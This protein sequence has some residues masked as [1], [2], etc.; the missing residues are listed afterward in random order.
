MGDD[1]KVAKGQYNPGVPSG[2]R[3]E[4]L[5]PT[6]RYQEAYAGIPAQMNS[7][8]TAKALYEERKQ[9]GKEPS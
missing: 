8:A 7:I 5:Q 2:P 3:L 6:K 1:D 4:Y 9:D